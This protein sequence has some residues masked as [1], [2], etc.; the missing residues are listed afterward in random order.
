MGAGDG[1]FNWKASVQRTRN[2]LKSFHDSCL[3]ES[4]QEACDFSLWGSPHG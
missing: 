3:Q 2:L 4:L 1:R